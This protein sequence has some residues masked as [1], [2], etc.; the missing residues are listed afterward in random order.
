M[1]AIACRGW[2]P[3]DHVAKKAGQVAPSGNTRRDPVACRAAATLHI[4]R[5][6]SGCSGLFCTS[7]TYTLPSVRFM[8]S[9]KS[10]A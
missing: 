3:A 7:L 2:I 4:A 10:S 9:L 5:I 6:T 8:N 1:P